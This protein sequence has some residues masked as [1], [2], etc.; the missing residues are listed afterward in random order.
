MYKALSD[1]IF[2]E[3]ELDYILVGE[4]NQK[5]NDLKI[6]TDEVKDVMFI[7][8]EQLDKFRKNNQIRRIIFRIKQRKSCVLC[9]FII[10]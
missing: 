3:Y 10:K 5:L 8:L 9:F 2:E 4:F 6:H 1:D 7:N